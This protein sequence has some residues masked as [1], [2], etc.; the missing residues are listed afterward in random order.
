MIREHFPIVTNDIIELT[1]TIGYN[2]LSIGGCQ[3]GIFELSGITKSMCKQGASKACY[4]ADA[5]LLEV[6][7]DCVGEVEI[8]LKELASKR[9]LGIYS[10]AVEHFGSS[11]VEKYDVYLACKKFCYYRI[12]STGDIRIIAGD[13]D[14][15][16]KLAVWNNMESSGSLFYDFNSEYMLSFY[17]GKDA[18]VPELEAK[19]YKAIIYDRMRRTAKIMHALL[20]ISGMEQFRR[21]IMVSERFAMY[22]SILDEYLRIREQDPIWI[23]RYT[24]YDE[25]ETSYRN[26]RIHYVLSSYPHIDWVD[27]PYQEEMWC[28]CD[29]LESRPITELS[30]ILL[31]LSTDNLSGAGGI[32]IKSMG[33]MMLA[34]IFEGKAY[35]YINDNKGE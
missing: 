11:E 5:M 33:N 4:I 3:I 9:T 26:M 32:L 28:V 13:V 12:T 25:E 7:H 15:L 20:H 16:E 24:Y 29:F 31:E 17:D 6:H 30:R 2:Q 1:I 34:R 19:N 21:N 14:K 18:K 27:A 35:S 8:L 10:I 22:L 23:S